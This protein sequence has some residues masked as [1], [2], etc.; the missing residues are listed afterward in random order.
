MKLL[1]GKLIADQIKDEIAREVKEQ[2]IDKGIDA[3]HLAAIL[4]GEDP[5]SMTYVAAKEKACRE[6]GFISSVYRYP[7]DVT[8][9]KLLAVID[10]LNADGEIDGFIV[11]VPLPAHIDEQKIIERIDPRKDIDGFHPVNI[12]KMV[13]SLPCF[14]PA[15]PMGIMTLLER[16]NIDTEGKNCVVLGRS[17][18]VGTPVS[19]L[20]SRKAKPGNGTV[21]LCH[22]HTKDIASIAASADI[23]VVA[24]GKM[25]FVTADMVKQNAV[26]VDVGIHRVPSDQTKSGFRLR[27]DV[28]FDEVSRKCSYITPVPGG[29]GLMTIVSLLQNTLKAAKKEVV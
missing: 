6:V 3:P 17:H 29:V 28:K 11:Q 15:T 19:I 5:A 21:T 23:L 26:V 13:L 24:M 1:D 16:Y 2:F 12:G 20:L 8:E 18:N 10:F 14:L 25:G 22:S 9:E 27:G 7:A 4:V